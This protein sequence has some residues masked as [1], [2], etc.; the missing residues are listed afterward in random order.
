MLLVWRCA[1]SSAAEVGSPHVLTQRGSEGSG[2]LAG[3]AQHIGLFQDFLSPWLN[4]FIVAELQN[5]RAPC[6]RRAQMEK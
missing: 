6:G 2:L 4:S 1:L 5:A 3:W